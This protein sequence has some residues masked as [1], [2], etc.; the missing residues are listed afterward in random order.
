MITIIGTAKQ[1]QVE[2]VYEKIAAKG[3]K[4]VMIDFLNNS[5]ITA[6]S[7]NGEIDIYCD[8]VCLNETKVV[9]H[10]PKY[11]TNNFGST[12][13]WIDKFLVQYGW[14]YANYSIFE[15]LNG[16]KLNSVHVIFPFFAK[17][18]QLQIANQYGFLTPPFVLANSK[19]QLLEF[20]HRYDSL[21]TKDIGSGH[22][23]YIEDEVLQ[24]S[25]MTSPI[26]VEM[27]SESDEKQP[28]PILVQK[29]IKKKYEYRVIVAGER[30]KAFRINPNQH[31][32]MQ[33]DYRRGGYMVEYIPFEFSAEL[34]KKLLKL[35]RSLNLFSGS[36]DFIEDEDG[37][38][39]FLEVNPAGVWAYIDRNL[40][41]EIS[42]MF[43]SEIVK[44]Y[45]T[46]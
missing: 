41:G 24:R 28:F 17:L 4:V 25:I 26:S 2:S 30:M 20:S 46:L 37:V 9:Y 21:I 42:D 13:D 3:I 19:E 34:Q 33:Q 15:L 27:I 14:K 29:N 1:Y 8:G 43:A 11:L 6:S 23:P 44:I 7:N 16:K 12:Q 10:D 5:S 36:Y 39:Y 38:L 40:N 18:K 35:H 22:I 32:I 45:E 31:P